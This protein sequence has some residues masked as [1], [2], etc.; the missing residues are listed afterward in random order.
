MNIY[1][2]A[3]EAAPTELLLLADPS[4]RHIFSYL[5]GSTVFVTDEGHGPIAVAV[6]KLN[7]SNA[8]LWNLA[9]AEH[10]QGCGLG[11][12]LIKH[13]SR[14]ALQRG[15]QQLQVGTGNSSFDAMAFYQK[16]GFRMCAVARDFFK[17][18]EPPIVENGIPCKDMILFSLDLETLNTAAPHPSP[19][20]PSLPY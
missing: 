4:L 15:A 18:Y 6:L 9:V 13:V 10:R 3:P 12:E 1:S 17:D 11:R 7:G 19:T 8:E 14:W 20:E 16:C 5:R 2:V